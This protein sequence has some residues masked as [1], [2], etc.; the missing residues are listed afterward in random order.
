MSIA[1]LNT[2]LLAS[3]STF[4][5]RLVQRKFKPSA[6]DEGEP[7]SA[8]LCACELNTRV[9]VSPSASLSYGYSEKDMTGARRAVKGSA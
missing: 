2:D 3:Q 8:C 4:Y 9:R 1:H 5:A 6:V 7:R